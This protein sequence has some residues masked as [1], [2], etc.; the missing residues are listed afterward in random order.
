[1]I[2]SIVQKIKENKFLLGGLTIVLLIC[3]SMFL[4]KIRPFALGQDQVVQYELF[5]EKWMQMIKTFL[6]TG[7]L[8]FYA[9]DNFLGTDFFTT[10]SYYVTG[11]F[12]VVFYLISPFSMRINLMLSTIALVYV[13]GL[14]MSIFLKK[15]GIKKSSVQQLVGFGYA[16]S[17]LALLYFSNSMFMRFYAFLPLLFYGVERYLQDKKLSFFAIVVAFLFLQSYYFMFPTSLFLILYFFVSCLMKNKHSIK[18]ILKKSFP[19]LGAYVVG[20]LISAILL[21]PTI[22]MII[23]HPRVGVETTGLLWDFKNILGAVY[24]HI[25]APFNLYSDIPYIFVSGTNGHEYWFS[26]YIGIF[27]FIAALQQFF[28]DSDKRRKNILG[29]GYLVLSLLVWIKPLNSIMHGF[30]EVSFRWMFLVVIYL[31]LAAA[32]ALDNDLYDR[33]KLKISYGIYSVVFLVGTGIGLTS[34]VIMLPDHQVHLSVSCSCLIFGWLLIYLAQARKD[35]AVV[36]LTGIE[37]SVFAV[38][39]CLILS[40]PAFQYTQTI[41]AEYVQYYQDTDED[42]VYRQYLSH[43]YLLPNTSLNLNQSLVLNYMSTSTYDSTFEPNL[44]DFIVAAGFNTHIVD[45]T[46]L[47]LLKMLGVKYY[48][49]SDS[50]E[51]PYGEGLEF[52]YVYDLNHLQVFMIKDYYSIGFT[53]DQVLSEDA[54]PEWLSKLIVPDEWLNLNLEKSE[55]KQ[56]EVIS[57]SMNSLTGQIEV[58]KETLLFLSVPYNKGWTIYDNGVEIDYQKVQLGFTGIL[59]SEGDHSIEMYYMPQG[60]KAGVVMSLSGLVGLIGLMVI[61]KK[62][63]SKSSHGA[64][65]TEE[66]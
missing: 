34:G 20:F 37:M 9:W 57:Q 24:S 49:V 11:D 1:M 51:I 43:Q 26:I 54:N 53:Y 62:K 63:Q 21:V 42:L 50:S 32:T 58:D 14:S 55:R 28:F 36:L 29:G 5:Y 30:S 33:K 38:A 17:G 44:T 45:I 13:A 15:W 48:I 7:E 52:E 18:A 66:E 46:N 6:R 22:I 47:E 31:C 8:P 64:T 3:F 10:K 61:D 27:L 19:L 60:F 59:L 25:T 4:L 23:N 35:K 12:F 39:F 40:N 41:N 2:R 16:L 65:Q 56:L